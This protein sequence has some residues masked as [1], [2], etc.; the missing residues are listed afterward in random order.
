MVGHAGDVVADNPMAWLDLGELGIL[1]WHA[2]RM[3]G[4]EQK[5]RVERSHRA[6]AIIRDC[7]IRIEP[8]VKKSFQLGILASDFGG[9]S[10]QTFRKA[11]DVLDSLDAAFQHSTGGVVD[12]V[13]SQAIKN[14]LER[15]V[16]F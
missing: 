15:L 13:G 11:A 4:E 10:G 2:V 8:G 9:E 3:L 7:W 12:Q 16:E 14:L 5:K 1:F 6:V